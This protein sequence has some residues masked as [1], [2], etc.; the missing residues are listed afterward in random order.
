MGRK[1][2]RDLDE[3]IAWME[4]D[5]P[6]LRVRIA[7]GRAHLDQA[8]RC[9]GVSEEEIAR[10]HAERRAWTEN[11]ERSVEDLSLP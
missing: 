2:I 6:R 8:L 7:R 10:R 11:L 3:L 5:E 4:A 9:V 1:H